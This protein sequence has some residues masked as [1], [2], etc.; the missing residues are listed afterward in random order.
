VLRMRIALD[1]YIVN[2][3]VGRAEPTCA[4]L[5]TL[6]LARDYVIRTSL[7]RDNITRIELE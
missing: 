5:V 6:S 1:D 3:A 7:F 2:R 4:W